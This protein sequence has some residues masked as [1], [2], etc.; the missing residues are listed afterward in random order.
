MDDKY[1]DK[2]WFAVVREVDSGQHNDRLLVTEA[3]QQGIGVFVRMV[4]S[5]KK[6]GAWISNLTFVPSA[7]LEAVEPSKDGTVDP[8][9]MV[10]IVHPH[11]DPT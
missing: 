7:M 6:L 1:Q 4:S 10:R 2:G 3:M 5:R 9:G 11:A 8:N